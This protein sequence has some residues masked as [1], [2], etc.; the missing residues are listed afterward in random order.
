[1]LWVKA[2]FVVEISDSRDEFYFKFGLRDLR[3]MDG[4]WLL[5]ASFCV[6]VKSFRQGEMCLHFTIENWKSN[7]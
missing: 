4:S 6:L 5:F 1:M 7:G 2:V 3:W